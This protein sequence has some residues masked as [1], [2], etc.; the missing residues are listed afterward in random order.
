MS[1]AAMKLAVTSGLEGAV[2]P[3]SA[4]VRIPVSPLRKEIG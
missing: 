4:L 3:P 1:A 2:L